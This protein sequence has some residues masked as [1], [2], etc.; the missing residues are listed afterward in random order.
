MLLAVIEPEVDAGPFLAAMGVLG[1]GMGLITSQLG[2]VVQSAVGDPDRSEAG[3][4]Q[5]TAQQLGS[6]LGT[7]LL[8]AVVIS[9]LIC[10][11]L[12]QR[13]GRLAHPGGREATG[14]DQAGRRRELHRRR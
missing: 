4:F 9:G 8:G 1:V 5:Y 11:V 3:G 14:R 6:S 13:G 7:A 12:R 10:V 2:N